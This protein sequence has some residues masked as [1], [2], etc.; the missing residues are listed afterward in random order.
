[1]DIL[2]PRWKKVEY[3]RNQIVN[4]GKAIRKENS[5]ENDL[6]AR[7]IIDNWRAAHAYPLQVMYNHLK[8]MAVED[9]SIVVAQ[10]LKRLESIVAKLRREKTMSLWAMQDLGGCRFIVQSVDDVYKY[11]NRL[12]SSRIRHK[13]IKADDYLVTPKPSGYRSLHAIYEFHSDKNTDYN[14]NM[15]IEIQFRTHLQ[16]L[17]ATAVETMG[18]FKNVAIK[19]GDGDVETQ[20]FFA[21][22]SSLFAIEEGL[23]T[24][25][26]TP[27]SFSDLVYE[28]KELDRKHNYLSFLNSIRV[29][30]KFEEDYQHKYDNMYCVL[31]LDYEHNKLT[32]KRF[33]ASDIELANQYY[34]EAEKKDEFSLDTVLVKVSS[35]SS[36]KAAYPNYFFDIS[37][38]VS[39]V[40]EYLV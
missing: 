17:W 4:A 34:T 28:I 40:K 25:P 26:Q 39:R 18:L 1:M 2:Q 30:T 3:S 29:V 20:R 33:R 21:L 24:V 35:F 11:F 8:R 6:L 12:K 14:R 37:E 38:F 22:V 36:L 19:S 13:F 31:S 32:I 10:R 16:H 15:M 23:P 7:N 5:P 27:E 9:S